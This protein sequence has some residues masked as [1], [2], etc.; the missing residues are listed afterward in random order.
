MKRFLCMLLLT[1]LLFCQAPLDA[2]A[3]AGEASD[4]L[5]V[6]G[7]AILPFAE[8]GVGFE[9]RIGDERFPF[10]DA[11]DAFLRVTLTVSGADAKNNMLYAGETPLGALVNGENRFDVP[12]SAVSDGSLLLRVLLS[13]GSDAL[14][15]ET[16]PYGSYNL[17]D[18]VIESAAFAYAD[19][20]E[21][22]PVRTLLYLPVQGQAGVTELES[23]QAAGIAVGDGWDASTG[24]GGSTPQTPVCV[25]FLLT[26]DLGRSTAVCTAD[27]TRLPDGPADAV[28]YDSATGAPAG[29]TLELYVCN[30]APDVTFPLESGGRLPAGEALTLTVGDNA[31]GLK[32]A[33]VYV[34][35]T[36]LQSVQAAGEVT[37]KAAALRTGANRVRVSTEDTA[38]NTAE[39]FLLFTV[40]ETPDYV[41]RAEGAGAAF[42]LDGVEGTLYGAVKAKNINMYQNRLGVFGYDALR[43]ST[44]T[45][46]PFADRA[47]IVTEAV[48]NSLPYQSFVVS[49]QRRNGG[50]VLPGRD[51]QRRRHSA[52][53]LQPPREP[54][55]HAVHGRQRRAGHLPRRPRDLLRGRQ[56][57]RHGDA[58]DRRQRQRHDALEHRH[59]VLFALRGSELPV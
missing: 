54:L 48:G 49:G 51:G 55:G 43:L 19:G 23:G 35:D 13:A 25:G 9:A 12:K 29:E 59:A 58:G 18:I 21:A 17:D 14:F 22:A 24:L 39:H 57:A 7:T 52:E 5:F 4:R 53:G 10:I 46:V 33:A 47:S 36:L 6:C 30:T 28:L 41:F 1:L 11:E 16:K 15:D 45:L 32:T 3:A 34:N 37:I 44:E 56:N 27:T 20:T 50:G 31:W 38:G 8:G 40:S 26:P 2:P 42:A